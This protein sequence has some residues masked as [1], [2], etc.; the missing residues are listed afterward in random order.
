VFLEMVLRLRVL[1]SLAL[2]PF[3][4]TFGFD[5]PTCV[6]GQLLDLSGGNMDRSQTY[7]APDG[8][9]VVSNSAT[10]I[11]K[12]FHYLGYMFD[13]SV[14]PGSGSSGFGITTWL[15][16]GNQDGAL[17][18]TFPSLKE[19]DSIKLRPRGRDDTMSD[20]RVSV[21]DDSTFVWTD[22][23]G[24][25]VD[26]GHGTTSAYTYGEEWSSGPLNMVTSKIKIDVLFLGT[27]G[28][29]GPSM[30]EIMIYAC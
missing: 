22:V 29:W 12:N 23:S 7:T 14:P 20:F 9:T 30:D 3:A 11:D 16:S 15:G 13:G 25:R 1:L 4:A 27:G 2:V 10:H 5:G 26:T 19:I 8:T 21:W 6:D 28:A 24:G 17:I 18:I